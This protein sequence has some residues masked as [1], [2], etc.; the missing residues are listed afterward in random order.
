M[1]VK[2]INFIRGVAISRIGLIGVVLTTS[3]FVTF[4]LLEAAR[5]LGLLTNTYVGL[6]TYMVFPA[7]FILGLVLIPIGWRRRKKATGLTTRQLL[8]RKFADPDVRA[9]F[10]G[11]RVFLTIGVFTVINILFMMG[12]SSRM[13]MF[14][15]TPIFCG[16]ACHSVMN[17]EWVTYRDSPHARVR[18]VDCHV[19]E[20]VEALVDSKLNG[21]WQIISVTFDLL[22]RPIPTPVRQLR[23]A[24]ETCEKCHWP[25]KFYGQRL[26]TLVRYGR[27]E[28]STPWYTTLGLKINAGPGTEGGGIHWHV[29]AANEVRYASVDD[30]REQMLWV[31]VR[32]SDSS[33]KRYN[34]RRLTGIE[35][36]HDLI[37][38]L[39]C[40][41]C[42]N[43]ATHIYEAPDH[44]I[45]D[46]LARG[47]LPRTLPYGKERALRA[48]TGG[49]TDS[50][51]AMDGIA[52]SVSEYYRRNYPDRV[53][54]ADDDITSMIRTLK[55][56][57]NRN[58]HHGMKITWN[59]YRSQIG[60]VGDGGCF[61]CHNAYLVDA[62][63]NSISADC[64]LCHSILAYEAD[65]PFEYI[66]P[67]DTT[68]PEYRMHHYLQREFF[69]SVGQ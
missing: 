5:L 45:D 39:D 58:I 50:A 4:V 43:R 15:D 30:K 22:E 18:C 65:K 52:N 51:A 55:A 61:R 24:R 53:D 47:R 64:T 3:S 62:A 14:M 17:P 13:L 60:H 28:T 1:L 67:P 42:H 63:G 33:F 68:D 59:C 36:D 26:K 20:G 44:A 29:A 38:T 12:A 7:L 10:F 40:I 41:D 2:Y 46:R 54:A 6:I 16:T 31:E 9:G 37:R 25:E 8:E 34:N 56:V 69:E 66:L 27:D 48:L 19:G 35:T 32:Q 11:S 49:Y 21:L 23:P 57:Y